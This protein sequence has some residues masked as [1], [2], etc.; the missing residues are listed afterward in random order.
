[1]KTIEALSGFI[2][3]LAV[4]LLA[5]STTYN[6]I[7]KANDRKVKINN[8]YAVNNTPNAINGTF[9]GYYEE[10]FYKG[11]ELDNDWHED[12]YDMIIAV[13]DTYVTMVTANYHNEDT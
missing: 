13:Y 8:F 2:V 3:F 11:Y 7:I 1:M 12:I 5:F 9:N 10:A 6:V 4:M